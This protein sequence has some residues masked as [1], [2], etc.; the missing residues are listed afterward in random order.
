MRFHIAAEHFTSVIESEIHT[1]RQQ[2]RSFHLVHQ[3]AIA[4]GEF[5]VIYQLGAGVDLQRYYLTFT[6]EMAPSQ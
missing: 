4:E 2:D 6:T 5:R 1:R 3:L